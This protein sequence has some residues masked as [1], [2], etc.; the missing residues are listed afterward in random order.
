MKPPVFSYAAPQTID[1]CLA[2]K[3]EHGE[4]A[5]FIAGGQSLMPLLNLRMV[6]PA[7]VIDLGKVRDLA[8]WRREGDAIVIGAMLR[9]RTLEQ[10]KE[11]AAALPLLAE[12]VRQ[13]GHPATRSR[14]TIVGSLCH[15]DPAAE[16]PVCAL[17]L[18]AQIVLAS[19]KG[20]RTIAAEEFLADALSTSIRDDELVE[21]VRLP[22][23]RRDTGYAFIELARRH[24]DF[25][26]ISVAASVASNGGAR[27]AIG[28]LGRA[29]V[30]F[31][32]DG[33]GIAA[34]AQRIAHGLEPPSD[35]HATAE[36][37]RALAQVLIERALTKA[38]ERSAT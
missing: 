22:A 18:K 6:R 13:I 35:L 29:P 27:V 24:G 32:V 1:E 34:E 12:A 7:V 3:A 25:A 5:R 38:A 28:G 26:L 15:A 23:G 19:A 17:L 36:Y 8:Y 33:Q 31:D 16:L 20:K 10:D 4:D 9:Q 14:G 21:Q 37:R 2:L 30:A 11:L